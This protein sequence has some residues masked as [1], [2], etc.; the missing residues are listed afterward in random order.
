MLSK[1]EILSL[2]KSTGDVKNAPLYTHLVVANKGQ[3]GLSAEFFYR[4]FAFGSAASV[5]VSFLV[6]QLAGRAGMKKAGTAA[7]ILMLGE[8][9]VQVGGDTGI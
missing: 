6:N 3:F 4:G 5:G 1:R 9:T 8:T 2:G 7:L